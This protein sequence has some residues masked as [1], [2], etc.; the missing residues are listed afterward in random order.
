MNTVYD[1]IALEQI[2]KDLVK[3]KILVTNAMTQLEGTM[4]T[5]N[6]GFLSKTQEA[7]QLVHEQKKAEYQRLISLL[8]EMPE[9]ITR[10]YTEMIEQDEALASDIRTRYLI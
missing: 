8:T 6:E 9:E 7:F 3:S 4:K 1:A 5:L 10:S 2:C